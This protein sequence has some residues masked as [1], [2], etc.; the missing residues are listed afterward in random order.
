MTSNLYKLEPKGLLTFKDKATLT[1]SLRDRFNNLIKQGFPITLTLAPSQI[2]NLS[3]YSLTT[4][5]TTGEATFTY[6]AP[7][8]EDLPS[9]RNEVL[10]TATYGT[11]SG[12]ATL[13]IER[14]PTKEELKKQEEEK[15]EKSAEEMQERRKNL[16]I[17]LQ[18][19]TIIQKPDEIGRME[20]FCGKPFEI[21]F[22]PTISDL[23]TIHAFILGEEKELQDLDG[24][25]VYSLQL[26]IDEAYKGKEVPFL[27][28]ERDPIGKTNATYGSIL[29]D[30]YGYVYE[31][32][33]KEEVQELIKDEKLV[34]KIA[35]QELRIENAVITLYIRDEKIKEWKR[36][37]AQEFNQENPQKTNKQGEYAFMVPEGLYYLK[38][39]ALDFDPYFSRRFKVEEAKPV[40]LN[41]RMT[42]S[43]ISIEKIQTFLTLIGIK[44]N[45]PDSVLIPLFLLLA[46][47]L[48]G[49]PLIVWGAMRVAR[50]RRKRKLES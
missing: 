18:G 12:E 43:F 27:I 2:G 8:Q 13:L 28:L 35:G 46:N 36:W 40:H 24:D 50:D 49:G 31:T 9:P 16:T 29:I 11:F 10:I 42:S 19:K 20:V 38:V 17:A 1:L 5:S 48:L 45:L 32:L 14:K 26:S 47:G 41:I 34:K 44:T 21:N 7:T 4:N 22:K 37:P 30:P 39:V 3:F 23:S 15:E 25:G 33:S 6:F